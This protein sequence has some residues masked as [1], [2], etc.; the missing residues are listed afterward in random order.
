MFERFHQDA[1]QAVVLAQ[2]NARRLHHDHVGTEHI[3]LGLL[4]QPQ[5]VSARVLGRH[6]VD[7]L[8]AYQA[9]VDALPPR[10][11][12]TLDADALEAIG[13]DLAAIREK[14]EAA[15][16]P[17][18]LDRPAHRNRRGRVFGGRHVRFTPRAK[19]TLELSLREAI[20]LKHRCIA[21]G[22]VLLGVLREGEGLGARVLADAGID[23]TALRQEIVAEL[24]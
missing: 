13:I 12:E 6:G 15:F 1:R 24:S 8:R 7:H 2:E 4:D 21:D 10:P 23:F 5:T 14:V 11:G 22:H 20:H 18:A 16:G 19:K 9:V 3:L 17:G